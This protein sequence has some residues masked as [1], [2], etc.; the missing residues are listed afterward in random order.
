MLSVGSVLP[1][2]VLER[3]LPNSD[4]PLLVGARPFAWPG[5]MLVLIHLTL[6]PMPRPS[7]GTRQGERRRPSSKQ[8]PRFPR[9]D[10]LTAFPSAQFPQSNAMVESGC[11]CYPT[12]GTELLKLRF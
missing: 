4:D 9:S 1:S 12:A 2:S 8:I 11:S 10:A 6:T 5:P 7:R 3:H